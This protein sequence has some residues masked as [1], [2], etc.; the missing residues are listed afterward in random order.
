MVRVTS[1]NFMEMFDFFWFGFCASHI[2][3]A[4]F[5]SDSDITSLL[6]TFMTFGLGSCC[7]RSGRLARAHP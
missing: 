7:G 6:F 1:G 5:P 3:H 4:F 2:A